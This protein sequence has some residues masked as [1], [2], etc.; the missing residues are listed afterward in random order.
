MCRVMDSAKKPLWLV[1]QYHYKNGLYLNIGTIIGFKI[2]S[3]SPIQGRM[4]KMLS[5]CMRIPNF[6]CL[7]T[8]YTF[9]PSMAFANFVAESIHETFIVAVSAYKVCRNSK[10]HGLIG[11]FFGFSLIHN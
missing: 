2:A 6:Y 8:I 3:I 5:I 11:F 9:Y 4:W 7:A 1:S 10:F